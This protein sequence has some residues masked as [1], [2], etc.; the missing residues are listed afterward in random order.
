MTE[1]HSRPRRPAAGPPAPTQPRASLFGPGA[2][3]DGRND[4]LSVCVTV[5]V[6][7]RRY[8]AELE[9]AAAGNGVSIYALNGSTVVAR[10]RGWFAEGVLTATALPHDVRVALQ[11]ALADVVGEER[12]RR[13][14]RQ[15]DMS[16]LLGAASTMGLPAHATPAGEVS[17]EF[18]SQLNDALAPADYLLEDR[19]RDVDFVLW[20]MEESGEVSA[21]ALATL[22]KSEQGDRLEIALPDRR[23]EPR[24]AREVVELCGIG[25][26]DLPA[27]REMQQPEA[28]E[29]PPARDFL[30][31]HMQ[32]AGVEFVAVDARRLRAAPRAERAEPQPLRRAQIR[33]RAGEAYPQPVMGKA[34]EQFRSVCPPG[35]HHRAVS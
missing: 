32:G 13:V 21:F 35:S 14:Q 7:E 34:I 10:A 3:A 23:R 24:E 31:Q 25:P 2:E 11:N 30:H 19:L 20:T 27:L 22:E 16:I 29:Q 9:P 33:A 5:T 8:A 6:S 1:D 4:A 17:F 18:L 12:S 26:G 15:S 28:A